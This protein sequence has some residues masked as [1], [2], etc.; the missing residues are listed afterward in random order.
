VSRRSAS[1][2][3]Q[4]TA[5]LLL[6]LAVLEVAPAYAQTQTPIARSQR[7]SGNINF[8]ATGGSLRTQ[9]NT[10]DACAVATTSS[11]TLSGVPAGTSI[12]AA[13]LYW[14]GS[15]TTSGGSPVV[16]PTVSLN[17]A[18]VTATRTFTAVYDNAGTLLP[19][20][21]AVADVTSRITGNGLY[22][23]GGLSVNTGAP[24]CA[25]AAVTGGWGLIVIYSGAGERLRAI[26]VFDGLQFF[27]G[28]SLTLTPDGFR[29]PATGIDGR[30]A[31]ITW[32]GDPGNSGPLNGFSE[33][34]RF[35][36]TL[37]DDGLV[38]AG[39][40]PVLQQ[41]DGTVNS[42]G[43]VSSY[44]ADVDTYDVSALLSPGQQ[45]ATTVYSSGGDL[46]LLAAQVVSATSEPRVDLRVS[47]TAATPF[48]VGSNASYTLSVSNGSASGNEREDN[49]ITVTD[50]LPAGLTFVSASGTGWTCAA[51]GQTVTC[52]RPPT[53][54]AGATAPPITLTVAV[55]A[56]AFP[57]V[58]NTATVASASF[59]LD[60][61]NDASTATT[62]VL[63]P[64]LSAS[65]KSVVDLNGGEVDPG[66]V[67][68]YT[69]SLIETGGVAVTGVDVLDDLPGNTTGFTLL[70]IPVGA[71]NASTTTGGANGAGLLDL[72][73]VTVPANG[74]VAITFEVTVVPT[75]SIG[76]TID[77]VATVTQPNGPGATPA[78]P[79]LVVSPSRLPAAG[80]KPLFLRRSAAGLLGLSRLQ[81]PATETSEAVPGGGSRTW[82]LTP[83]LQQ[84]LSIAAGDIPVR[85]YLS[86]SSSGSRTL[87]VT[88]ANAAAGFSTSVT[89]SATI[90]T[91]TT[92]PTLVTFILP[93]AIARSFPAGSIFTLT[94]EQVS[95]SSGT[96][97]VHPFGA[98]TGWTRNSRIEFDATTVIDVASVQA[99]AAPYPAGTV[100]SSYAPGTSIW[101][102]ATVT[103]PFG[104]FDITGASVTIV[105]AGATT[106]VAAAAMTLVNDDGVATRIYE[107]PYTLPAGGPVG[108]WSLQ[109]VATEGTEGL[110]A[111]TGV[112][113]LQV[114]VPPPQLRVQKSSEV[115]SDPVN[116]ASSPR[117]IPGAIVRYSVTVTNTGSGAVDADSLT[118]QDVLPADTELQVNAGAVPVVE[119]LQGS[120]ASGLAF[121]VASGVGYSNQPGGGAPFGYSPTPD[122]AGFDAAVRGIRIAPSGSM[123]ASGPG[124]DPSFTVRFRVRVR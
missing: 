105:D 82:T 75:T 85:L 78:A 104:S 88:L 54:N 114:A 44:G 70:A 99:F 38:P 63:R 97:R 6:L 96:T 113:P 109:V 30:L 110:V 122:A 31:V 32:E 45:S 37:L 56:A 116:G 84:S 58:T 117:R 18:S 91:S 8:V 7:F 95:P 119:F 48:V 61:S 47:K 36:G 83:P 11:Q 71:T 67:L 66:D 26:N 59:D 118:I 89:Q 2:L 100:A 86:R 15:T 77:N 81:A 72:R 124:G 87:A 16:D 43:V 20:F 4:F 17:G 102:R 14:G 69:I 73:G 111:D 92:T 93:N 3:R 57:S 64:D 34:L 27:R 19:F 13:Y 12:V 76:A 50:V 108:G 21:G 101:V 24:H 107:Y 28:N 9:P 103:D 90:T 52:T 115:L 1:L 106:R 49:V 68:R 120:P 55:G 123:A 29:I 51:S 53:L 79:S 10:G 5:L 98:G 33:S 74:T 39:S 22:T 25:V 46:V 121:S 80:L 112:G 35:N 40:D 62:A 60:S 94:V 23:F 42:Q 65:T 41:F